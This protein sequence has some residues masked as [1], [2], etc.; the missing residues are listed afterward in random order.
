MADT[1][2]KLNFSEYLKQKKAGERAPKPKKPEVELTTHSTSTSTSLTTTPVP[3]ASTEKTVTEPT[4]DTFELFRI[5]CAEGNGLP[6]PLSPS[7]P[8]AFLIQEEKPKP[9]PTP[10]LEKKTEGSTTKSERPPKITIGESDDEE[11][12]GVPP[13]PRMLSPTL[14]PKYTLQQPSPR[15]TLTSHNLIGDDDSEQDSDKVK[16]KEDKSSWGQEERT[17]SRSFEKVEYLG[18]HSYQ[19]I[20]NKDSKKMLLTLHVPKFYKENPQI[21]TTKATAYKIRKHSQGE[22]SKGVVGLGLKLAPKKRSNMSFDQT[23]ENSKKKPSL[24]SLAKQSPRE[25]SVL[26]S[27]ASTPKPIASTPTIDRHPTESFFI[28]K[29]NAYSKLAGEKKHK[30]DALLSKRPKFAIAHLIESLTLFLAAYHYEDLAHY[31][32]NTPRRSSNWIALAKLANQ[33]ARI[34]HDEEV[35]DMAG[36]ALQIQG[37][38]YDH[39]ARNMDENIQSQL[40]RKDADRNRILEQMKDQSRYRTLSERSLTQAESYLSIFDLMN[41]YKKIVQMFQRQTKEYG[42][43]KSKKPSLTTVEPLKEDIRLPISNAN[44]I[45][46]MIP[47]AYRVGKQ[48]CFDEKLQYTGWKFDL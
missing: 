4:W 22:S 43:S 27:T 36:L 25:G 2:T 35:D 15:R 34:F 21:K 42:S 11:S 44:T 45:R 30:G 20:Q 33:F 31:I 28:D 8:R 10:V 41:R 26:N 29:C 37:V 24:S 3:T 32:T 19:L 23:E 38:V 40:A 13:I 18:V 47:Y 12:S 5:A 46:E 6:P 9:T 7:I 39:V 16:P 17:M 14:P 48:W 1:T